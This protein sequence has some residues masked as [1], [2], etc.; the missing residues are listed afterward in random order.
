MTN[1]SELLK[2]FQIHYEPND[3][4][5][6]RYNDQQKQ[7]IIRTVGT[8]PEEFLSELYLVV[9]RTH[10]AKFRS[11]PDAAVVNKAMA[12]MDDPATYLPPQ[13]QLESPMDVDNNP[14]DRAVWLD[15]LARIG[16]ELGKQADI[17]GESNRFERERVRPRVSKNDATVYERWWIHVIDDLGGNWEAMPEGWTGIVKVG[18][19]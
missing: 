3:G 17:A 1:A 13:K 12:S 15:F 14:S 10:E 6:L 18:A 8:V 7:D 16:S 5:Q 9:M 2:A 19:S 11:L 4:G